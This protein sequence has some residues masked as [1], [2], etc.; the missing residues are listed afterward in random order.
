MSP[1]TRRYWQACADL[2]RPHDI[3]GVVHYPDDRGAKALIRC[4]EYTILALDA[5]CDIRSRV[6]HLA[7]A[8]EQ[9]GEV[10]SGYAP[11]EILSAVSWARSLVCDD[12]QDLAE[13]K[14]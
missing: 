9:L 13:G 10:P 6:A 12:V 5:G 8:H 3:A 7:L 1:E 4:A 2:V 14:R 11:S